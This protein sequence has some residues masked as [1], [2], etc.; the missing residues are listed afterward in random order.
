MRPLSIH[1]LLM[2]P[3]LRLPIEAEWDIP[4]LSSG[5][6][7]FT[8]LSPWIVKGNVVSE[9]GGAVVIFTATVSVVVSMPCDR[10]MKPVKV[11]LQVTVEQRFAKDPAS[12]TEAS[13]SDLDFD[14]LPIENDQI[15]LEEPILQ[16]LQLA[17]PMK[18]VCQE[19]CKGL[20]P[21]CGQ[22]LNLGQC[23]CK[24]DNRDPRWDALKGLFSE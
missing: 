4:T 13:D 9:N 8:C 19:D 20:C 17:I 1:G 14:V 12:H 16:E 2:D 22:D 18:V 11:P 7:S 5:T 21:I 3:D 15:D 24:E 10:C 23:A 6:E